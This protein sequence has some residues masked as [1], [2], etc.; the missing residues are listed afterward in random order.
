MI[1]A[2]A[3][4]GSRMVM[5]RRPADHGVSFGKSRDTRNL[6][7]R[8]STTTAAIIHKAKYIA[9]VNSLSRPASRTVY[10]SAYTDLTTSPS[11]H[12][13]R[14]CARDHPYDDGCT[15]KPPPIGKV[16]VMRP[17]MHHRAAIRAVE[18]ARAGT[19][20]LLGLIEPPAIVAGEVDGQRW[21]FHSSL[22]WSKPRVL[23]GD[24][25]PG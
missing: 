1:S 14:L 15:L 17:M 2:A 8:N 4:R 5:P 24:P 6:V 19:A 12:P 3:A 21:R 9:R 20:L 11:E 25:S 22:H 13:S 23:P 18:M 7:T 10:R 16:M